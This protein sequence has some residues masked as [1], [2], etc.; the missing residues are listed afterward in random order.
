MKGEE[1]KSD[2][3]GSRTAHRA[4]RDSFQGADRLAVCFFG[5]PWAKKLT[6]EPFRI[7]SCGAE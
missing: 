2:W 1:E 5:G 7:L 3:R 6:G 4:P